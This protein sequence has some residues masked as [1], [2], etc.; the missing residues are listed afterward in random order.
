MAYYPNPLLAS[1]QPTYYPDYPVSSEY[2]SGS[3]RV[4][5]TG[6]N[7]GYIDAPFQQ[8][9]AIYDQHRWFTKMGAVAQ[10]AGSLNMRTTQMNP[11]PVVG[12][13]HEPSPEEFAHFPSSMY[14][15]MPSE[16]RF[17]VSDSQP[18]KSS[19]P[20]LAYRVEAGP[21]QSASS[22]QQETIRQP[23]L[24][25]VNLSSKISTNVNPLHTGAYQMLPEPDQYYRQSMPLS[26]Q[27]LA[28]SSYAPD[29]RTSR[30]RTV[31]DPLRNDLLYGYN[32]GMEF[33]VAVR[34]SGPSG[35]PDIRDIRE[36]Q[37]HD[38]FRFCNMMK[39]KL[40]PHRSASERRKHHRP[41]RDAAAA[42]SVTSR[43]SRAQGYSHSPPPVRQMLAVSSRPHTS[44]P[45]AQSRNLNNLE[46]RSLQSSNLQLSQAAADAGVRSLEH[47]SDLAAMPVAGRHFLRRNP[48]MERLTGGSSGTSSLTNSV[49]FQFKRARPDA[50]TLPLRYRAVPYSSV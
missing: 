13:R 32:V 2:Q 18:Q 38:D 40:G 31:E 33:D 1:N 29:Y 26:T 23:T 20:Q 4:F 43:P 14:S 21:K 25:T 46:T 6:T 7:L 22:L 16:P 34:S 49:E 47:F 45:A 24:L 9:E 5:P 50:P 28:R 19:V 30:Y 42:G 27:P 8:N 3:S 11:E 15:N 17:H 39:R 48:Q 35:A 41:A 37:S 10:A 12:F 44:H 36:E